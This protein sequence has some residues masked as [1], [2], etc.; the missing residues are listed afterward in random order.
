MTTLKSPSPAPSRILRYLAIILS[1]FLPGMYVAIINFHPEIFPTTLFLRIAAT[2]E[3]VP[4]PVVLE[5]LIMESV[6]EVCGRRGSAS[7]PPSAPPSASWGPWSWGMPPSAPASSPRRGHRGG[8]DGHR[9]LCHPQ[10]CPGHCRPP[11]A[12]CLHRPGGRLWPF[13]HPVR[14]PAPP[15][16]R[17]CPALLRHTLHVPFRPL[18]L[19]GYDPGP[20][21]RTWNWNATERPKLTGFREPQGQH[22]SRGEEAHFQILSRD[23]KEEGTGR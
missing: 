15:H 13:R 21:F 10:L 6:F 19:G 18:N 22:G 23:K 12:L 20:L 2:R 14:H 17:L 16:S 9:F 7:P 4:F 11:S 1:T 3:G 8:P 5:L